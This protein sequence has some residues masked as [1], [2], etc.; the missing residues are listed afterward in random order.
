[1]AGLARLCKMY[2]RMEVQ[3]VMWAWDYARD[4]A[5]KESEL[6]ADRQRWEASERARAELMRAAVTRDASR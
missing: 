3:G 6:K 4:E 5:V 1:M 2:G